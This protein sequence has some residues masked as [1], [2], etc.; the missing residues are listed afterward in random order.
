[1]IFRFKQAAFLFVT[2]LALLNCN[3]VFSLEDATLAA[4]SNPS[5]SYNNPTFSIGNQASLASVQNMFVGLIYHNRY[6]ISELG[7]QAFCVKT[8]LSKG[9]VAGKFSYFGTIPYHQM[10]AS[11]GYGLKLHKK[12]AVG[13]GMNYF[14]TSYETLEENAHGIAG[15]IGV[16]LFPTEHLNIGLQYYNAS[17]STYIN[18]KRE[19]LLSGMRAGLGYHQSGYGIYTELDMRSNTRPVFKI[20]GECRLYKSLILHTGVSNGDYAKYSFGLGYQLN[21]LHVNVAFTHHPYLGL[22]SY[23]TIGYMLKNR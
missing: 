15:D 22:S 16:L 7:E 4:M 18:Y 6:G 11:L 23:L 10:H 21:S 13:V 20:G 8:P 5:V 2:S 19:E 1:M 9:S 12:I 17:N 14:T 3:N